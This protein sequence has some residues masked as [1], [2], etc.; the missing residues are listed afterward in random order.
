MFRIGTFSKLT[1]VSVKTL[2]YYDQVGL[3]KAVHTDRTTGYRYFAAQQVPRLNRILALKDLGFSL[4]Q[5]ARLLND[6]LQPAQILG[7]LQMKQ[8]EI[9]QHVA[10]EEN[11]LRRVAARLQQIEQEDT[12]GDYDI[13]VKGIVPQRAL[14][15]R[16][17]VA[18]CGKVVELLGEL[19]AFLCTHKAKKAGPVLAIYYD[20]GYRQ[21][22]L[23]A[24]VAIPV[25]ESLPDGDHVKC[26]ELPGVPAMASI[27]HQGRYETTGTAYG[28]LMKWSESSGNAFSA[29]LR[30][31]YLYEPG[32]DDDPDSLMIEIQFPLE[33]AFRGNVAVP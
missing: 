10:E 3:L 8:A 13:V 15:V 4:E 32:P 2:R 21:C 18:G 14:T 11:R 30:E 27:V 31:I 1:Q 23:D 9:Q 19:D 16:S 7:M 17:R 29:P 5:I 26:R 22:D 12:L 6:N 20:A 25:N 28:A 24:E 33:N